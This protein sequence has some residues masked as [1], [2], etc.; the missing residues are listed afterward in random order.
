[1]ADAKYVEGALADIGAKH[2]VGGFAVDPHGHFA[3]AYDERPPSFAELHN[4]AGTKDWDALE[5][6]NHYL[7]DAIEELQTQ[8]VSLRNEFER[9][10]ETSVP[11]VTDAM[12]RAG[13][14]LR[15]GKHARK[16]HE[17]VV[18]NDPQYVVFCDEK[19][20]AL[21]LGFTL[22]E[23]ADAKRYV[24]ESPGLKD[25]RWNQ[26]SDRAIANATGGAS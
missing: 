23:I 20:A 14:F 17:W 22:D 13:R 4:L 18:I 7:I 26:D 21:A 9:L 1:M 19:S 25:R 24:R 3:E 6:M 11:M 10:R 8:H 2:G 15:K 12:R 16:P 5:R